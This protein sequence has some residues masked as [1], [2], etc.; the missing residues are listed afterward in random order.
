MGSIY[1]FISLLDNEYYV[2]ITIN[3]QINANLN[4]TT[5]K[6]KMYLFFNTFYLIL[7]CV[8]IPKMKKLLQHMSS[9]IVMIYTSMHTL[10]KYYSEILLFFAIIK[11]L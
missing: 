11:D 4:V 3:S 10:L 9:A 8:F 1:F 6:R 2:L 7:F 5:I